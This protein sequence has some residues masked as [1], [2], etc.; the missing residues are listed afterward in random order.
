MRLLLFSGLENHRLSQRFFQTYVS[1]YYEK[2][3]EY[4]TKRMETGEFRKVNSNLAARGFLGMLVYHSM[5]QDIFGGSRFQSF[6]F[7]DVAREL[8]DIWLQGMLAEGNGAREDARSEPQQL[9]D[10]ARIPKEKE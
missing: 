8:T 10:W 7:H 4:I 5:V 9:D 1:D 3:G 2:I 6:D